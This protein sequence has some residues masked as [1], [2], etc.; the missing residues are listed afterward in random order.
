MLAIFGTMLGLFFIQFFP[1][2]K[3]LERIVMEAISEKEGLHTFAN[4]FV[5]FLTKKVRFHRNAPYAQ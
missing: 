4:S 2:F 3:I 1:I 5:A